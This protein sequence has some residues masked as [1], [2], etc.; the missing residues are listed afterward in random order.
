MNYGN[1]IKEQEIRHSVKAS[2][3]TQIYSRADK[4]TVFPATAGPPS[5]LRFQSS[6]PHHQSILCRNDVI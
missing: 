4:S 1:N 5:S 2:T 3:K 6:W